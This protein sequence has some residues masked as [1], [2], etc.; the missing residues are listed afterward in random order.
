MELEIEILSEDGKVEQEEVLR[1][2]TTFRLT[3]R[4][5][6]DLLTQEAEVGVV[7]EQ[8]QHDEVGIKTVKTV[9]N[10]GVVVRLRFAETN[11]LHDL[12][13]TLTRDVVSREDDLHIAPIRVF[14]DLLGDEVF[15]L[16]GEFGHKGCTGR[17]TVGVEGLFLR[18]NFATALGLFLDFLGFLGGSETTRTLLVHLSSRRNTIDG[19]EE[20]LLGFNLVEE[21]LYIC[22]D[23]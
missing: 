8:T 9:T 19:E 15:E 10:I 23:C 5:E 22:K 21:M 3:A 17:D 6:L 1:F 14:G 20:N 18:Q 13:L 11:V 7:T 12:V 2:E 4:T 16:L